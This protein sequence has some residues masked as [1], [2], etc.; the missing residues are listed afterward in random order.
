M[1][2]SECEN[3]KTRKEKYEVKKEFGYDRS[4][5]LNN[6][7]VND[8]FLYFVFEYCEGDIEYIYLLDT[9]YLVYSFRITSNV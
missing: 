4:G 3:E 1:F 8:T 7:V 2:N 6:G 5:G 9:F